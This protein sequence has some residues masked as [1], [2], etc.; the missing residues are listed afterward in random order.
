M[1]LRPVNAPLGSVWRV[2][3]TTTKRL[4]SA[5][6]EAAD[7]V[8]HPGPDFAG[9]P[10]DRGRIA[11]EGVDVLHPAHG[12]TVGGAAHPEGAVDCLDHEPVAHA[13]S[14][15]RRLKRELVASVGQ[16]LVPVGQASSP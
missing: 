3:I 7:R 10:V 13:K 8:D 12:R 15:I 6:I 16:P 14:L 2:V 11:E 1:G 5:W 9:G 4:L